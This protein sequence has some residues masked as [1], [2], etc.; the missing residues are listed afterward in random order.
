MF[1][2]IQY[3]FFHVPMIQL[4][5]YEFEQGN[6]IDKQIEVNEKQQK[7]EKVIA[8]FEKQARMEKKPKKILEY[9]LNLK[10]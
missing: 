7:L 4:N 9:L 6:T 5:K 3:C 1:I 2:N 8:K 10:N